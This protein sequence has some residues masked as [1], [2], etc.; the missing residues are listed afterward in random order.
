MIKKFLR[1]NRFE[2]I[3]TIVVSVIIIGAIIILVNSSTFE[4]PA[5]YNLLPIKDGCYVIVTE[6]ISA[7]PANNYT[8]I[9]Y[10]VGEQFY[11]G[12]GKVQ[13]YNTEGPAK[14]VIRNNNIVYGDHYYIYVPID[15]IQIND[16]VGTR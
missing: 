13:F 2:I 14:I 4:D 1:Q 6:C 16:T 12:K 11:T 3:Y 10:R 8:M 9:F 5:E 15:M 7:I